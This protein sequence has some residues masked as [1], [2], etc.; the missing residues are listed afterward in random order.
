MPGGRPNTPARVKHAKGNPGGRALN[1]GALTIPIEIPKRP[2]G[3]TGPLKRYWDKITQ[4]LF[5]NG[6]I[7][8]LDEGAVIR[9]CHAWQQYDLAHAALKKKGIVEGMLQ[10]TAK[11]N[12]QT[13][14][15]LALV[16]RDARNTMSA[17]EAQFGMTPSARERV[18]INN[19]QIGLPFTT[20]PSLN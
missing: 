6:L 19:N 15:G 5:D 8:L 3:M 1:L 16:I 4:I 20:R 12:Y 14:S 18:S 13:L 9:Y 2:R 10:T 7:T 11:T 17:L